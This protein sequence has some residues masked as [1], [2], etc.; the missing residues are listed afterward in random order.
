MKIGFIGLGI[1]GTPMALH[2]VDAGH[3]LYVHTRGKVPE[4][5]AAS[6]AQACANAAEV[7]GHADVDLHHGARHARRR[8]GAVRRERRRRRP[9]GGRSARARPS[10]T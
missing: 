8:G 9:E 4:A 7:A 6:T 3:Q 1:M 10:S 2:L 5:I